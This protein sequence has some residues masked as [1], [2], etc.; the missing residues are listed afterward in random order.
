MLTK[1]IG[2]CFAGICLVDNNEY[3]KLHFVIKIGFALLAESILGNLKCLNLD[4]N[5]PGS[6]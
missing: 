4:I 2:T 5:Y 6:L 3:M 1:K